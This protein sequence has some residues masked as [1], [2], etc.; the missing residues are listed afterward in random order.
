MSD[1]EDSAQA[2]DKKTVE[3]EVVQP[4]LSSTYLDELELAVKLTPADHPDLPRHLHRL[5]VSFGERYRRLG[6]LQDLE[7]ALENDQAAAKLTPADHP[8]LPQRLQSHAVSFGHRYRRLGDLQDL[9]SA[10]EN[11]QAAVKLTPADHPDLPQRLQNLAVSFKE[12]YRRLGGLQDLESALENFQ[13]AVKL[14]PA[15]HPDL[16]RRLQHLAASFGDRYQRLGDL[17]DL[18]SALENDQAAVRLTPANHPDLPHRIQN[19]AMSFKDRYRRLGDLQDLESALENDQAA[20][21]LT[22]ANHPDLPQRLQNLAMS[23]KDRYRRLGDLQDLESGLENNQAAVKLTPADHPDLPCCFLSLAESLNERYRRLGDL[24]DL[25][26]ALENDQA[27]VK[28]T[29]ADHPDLP[30]RLQNLAVSFRDRY[31]RLGDL[32]DL[33]SAL[34]NDQAAVKLTPAGHPDLPC[35]LQALA[36][37]FKERYRRLG[38]L[39]DLESALENDQ[40]A[41]KLTH[42]DHPD[43]PQHLQSLAV[44]FKERYRRLGGLQDLESAL[45]ND[46]APMKLTPADHPDL[47]QRLQNLA[48]SFRDRYRRLGDP[49]DLESALENNQAAV[50]LTP[51]DHPDL[52]QRLQNLAVFLIDRYHH[53]HQ[54]SDLEEALSNYKVSFQCQSSDLVGSWKAALQWASVAQHYRP[55]D[56]LV[57]YSN[58]FK[59]LP[60]ILWIGSTLTAHQ[61]TTRRINITKAT[62]DA[63]RACI[64]HCNLIL[65]IELH[66]QGLATR[67]QQML[68]LK[69]DTKG[70]P[71][72]KAERFCWL[73][74]QLY[75]G[76][77]EKPLA[78]VNGRTELL[79]G[80]KKQP[81]FENFL[82]PKAYKALSQAAQDGPIIILNSHQ[83][84]CDAIVLLNPKSN[85]IHVPL[86]DVTLDGLECQQRILKDVLNDCNVRSRHSEATRLLGSREAT[87][88]SFDDI[89][90]W[91]WTKI[92]AHIYMALESH[93]IIAG[94][95]WWCPT[96]AF[97]KLP[98]HA[99]APS[100]Q[101]VQSYTSTL[102]ALLQANSKKSTTSDALPTI[103]VVGVTHSGPGRY[104]ALP[105]VQQEIKKI[106]SIVGEQQVQSLVG[107]QATAEAVKLQLQNCAWVH[108]ACH[109]MQ[110]ISDP[111]KSH[112]MLYEGTLDMET[113]LHMSLPNAEVVFLAACQ[114]AMGD[115]QMANESFHLGGGFIAAGFRGAIGT[116]WSMQ[117][118]DG[119]IVAETVYTHLFANGQKPQASDAAKA[120]QVAMRKLQND[121]IPYERWVP[122]IHMG[123]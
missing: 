11:D 96:G 21:R 83:D 82:E 4:D 97:T 41:M 22:P 98:L 47:P 44:S 104:A 91:L 76:I 95:I 48:A 77:C 8:D 66:E 111:P 92:V 15:D 13:A 49:Q 7:S 119:P 20:V 106:V 56:T 12:R 57:A 14:T 23:F 63:I 69:A 93:G 58:A 94:R 112:R 42:A 29:P 103:G 75:G 81:G 64:D 31:Q 35:C 24:Q 30:Q 62:S 17:Q 71:Q 78:I 6:E 16:P 86:L 85:P 121:G 73:S 110:D 38:D 88:N 5:A 33:E 117:D 67:F 26:S 114:T 109:G 37:S 3:L 52:P 118:L 27:A 9:A 34:E 45:E 89:I 122:F 116:M 74:S 54:S 28:L 79:S 72:D 50:K 105:G 39:Q 120:L 115:A 32:Q 2:M 87:Q 51:A 80:I 10:L 84:H 53:L 99:A 61:D 25:E 113:I 19:L 108:L 65:A 18:E 123:I 60:E 40:A 1:L 36:L 100:D 55:S 46:Q 43:L 102:G 107:E 90:M 59:L 68:H 70:I 101:F